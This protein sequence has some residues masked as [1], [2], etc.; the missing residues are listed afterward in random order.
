MVEKPSGK[1]PAPE[2]PQD[3]DK[4]QRQVPSKRP[5][6]QQESRQVVS[7]SGKEVKGIVRLAGRDL[8]GALPLRRAITSVRGIG[9]NMGAVVSQIACR[10]LGVDDKTMVGELGEPEIEKLEQIL[11][12]QTQLL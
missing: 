9:I 7:A 12:H 5:H 8:R 4:K 1:K 10:E 2:K 11:L 6:G 3:K